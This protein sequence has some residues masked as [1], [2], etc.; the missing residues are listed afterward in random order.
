VDEYAND[1]DF[2]VKLAVVRY[3]TAFFLE[4]VE[5]EKSAGST[6]EI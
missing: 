5:I 4:R 2:A 3:A 1:G 6:G